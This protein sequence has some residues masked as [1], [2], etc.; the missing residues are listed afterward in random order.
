MNEAKRKPHGEFFA[1]LS[2]R[3]RQPLNGAIEAL[4]DLSGAARPDVEKQL[5]RLVTGEAHELVSLIND[6]LDWVRL[7]EKDLPFWRESFDLPALLADL[8]NECEVE[9]R[10]RGVDGDFL[11]HPDLTGQVVGDPGRVRQALKNLI[12]ALPPELGSRE[13]HLSVD[14]E[15]DRAGEATV[16]FAFR[17][18]AAAERSSRLRWYFSTATDVAH[19]STL[20]EAGTT[21][22]LIRLTVAQMLLLTMGARVAAE[23]EATGDFVLIVDWPFARRATG[24]DGRERE[25]AVV[26]GRRI[27][28]IT[29]E[30]EVE[31]PLLAWLDRWGCRVQVLGEK[32]NCLG[33]LREAVAWA[34]PFENIIFFPRGNGQTAEDLGRAI[35]ADD[36]LRH[37]P[38]I[39][40]TPAGRRGD[41][42]RLR[43]IG[44]AAYLT[45]PIGPSELFRTL[46][47][48]AP[49]EHGASPATAGF[50][51]RHVLRERLIRQ[52]RVGVIDR[53]AGH[54]MMIRRLL[55]EAGCRVR[56]Y[57]TDEPPEPQ[58]VDL[59]FIDEADAA[60]VAENWGAPPAKATWMVLLPA[61]RLAEQDTWKARGW[62]GAVAKP[63]TSG[64]LRA[65]I[66]HSL[67]KL[68]AADEPAIW[69][70]R[71]LVDVAG[72]L[73]HFDQDRAVLR[74]VLK[75]FLE[76][77]RRQL[78]DL[79][80]ALIAGE[81][82]Q[83][84]DWAETIRDAAAGLEI[85][86]LPKVMADLELAIAAGEPADDLLAEADHLL[87]RIEAIQAGI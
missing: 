3:V 87:T 41:A 58:A 38:L 13:L 68:M 35:R 21:P 4:A 23:Q 28:L 6:I 64:D 83:A 48:L 65:V 61:D 22:P 37:T 7:T 30:P 42:A 81:S 16:R 8:R 70:G 72:L 25:N 78:N 66:H 51:T 62:D 1:G 34:E 80:Q 52:V 69:L 46:A 79:R 77:S 19:A 27:C 11:A 10:A 20:L 75:A 71:G 33:K 49:A 67:Q 74:E 60:A 56:A 15:L 14:N 26:A 85:D 44:F 86:R 24:T 17:L 82:E 59:L 45:M 31:S 54:E 76:D 53:Q 50:I 5:L 55:E 2:H 84:R 39:L 9:L 47:L 63:A 32:P 36:H 57:R 43:G 40:V 73:A 18:P 12:L 29:D